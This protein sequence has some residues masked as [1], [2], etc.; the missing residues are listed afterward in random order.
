[1]RCVAGRANRSLV[2]TPFDGLAV[3]TFLILM[4]NLRVAGAAQLRNRF[5]EGP[6]IGPLQ[7]VGVTM[8]D[9][10]VRS[11]FISIAKL[12]PVYAARPLS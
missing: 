2:Y 8:A 1:M 11:S 5:L 12:H 7:L 3:N 4:R 10:A 6:R 9:L